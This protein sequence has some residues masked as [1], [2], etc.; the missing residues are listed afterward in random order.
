MKMDL[1]N[2]K[3]F[4]EKSPFVFPGVEK[5]IYIA[6]KISE[7]L[8]INVNTGNI[9]NK[10]EEKAI[11]LKTGRP[12]VITLIRTDYIMKSIDKDEGEESWNMSISEVLVIGS[13]GLESNDKDL[14]SLVPFRNYEDIIKKQE[15]LVNIFQIKPKV[16]QKTQVVDLLRNFKTEKLYFNFIRKY[17]AD[18]R[19]SPEDKNFNMY[20]LTK[21]WL[22]EKRRLIQEN[23]ESLEFSDSLMDNAFMKIIEL[24]F[25]LAYSDNFL[26]TIVL[27]QLLLFLSG[28][29]YY[30]ISCFIYWRSRRS[31]KE[32]VVVGVDLPE[33][34]KQKNLKLQPLLAD[35]IE[36]RKIEMPLVDLYKTNGKHMNSTMHCKTDLAMNQISCVQVY[37]SKTSIKDLRNG[38]RMLANLGET[39]QFPENKIEEKVISTKVMFEKQDNKLKKI[40]QSEIVTVVDCDSEVE[41]LIGKWAEELENYNNDL[42][43]FDKRH[44]TASESIQNFQIEMHCTYNNPN[45]REETGNEDSKN[46][47]ELR[48]TL[49]TSKN[50]KYLEDDYFYPDESLDSHSRPAITIRHRSQVP[51]S[52]FRVRKKSLGHSS[53]HGRLSRV[54]NQP[55]DKQVS[56]KM[57][58]VK[59]DPDE[60]SV[61][62]HNTSVA[63]K[64]IHSNHIEEGRLT[65]NFADL[66]PIGKGGF[67]LVLK[68]THRIEGNF[69]AIKIIKLKIDNF[70]SLV[71][72]QVIKEAKTM[73]KLNHKNVVK[74]ITCWFQTDIEEVL[75][76]EIQENH[77]LIV[78]EGWSQSKY[79]V[80]SKSKA[81]N[82]KF[83]R[84]KPRRNFSFSKV[85]DTINE[86]VSATES[87]M[88]GLSFKSK[89]EAK[90]ERLEAVKEDENDVKF[91]DSEDDADNGK[92]QGADCLGV[93][94]ES[95]K[96]LSISF[97]FD[98]KSFKD[99]E[100]QKRNRKKSCHQMKSHMSIDDSANKSPKLFDVFFIM[101]MEF[102]DGL[103]L[104]TYLEDKK[105][106]GIQRSQIF[107]FF[108][109][110][111]S[112]VIHMHNNKVVHRDIK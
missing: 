112:G 88:S 63:E 54:K 51:E 78:S 33:V 41:G 64:M 58:S 32:P 7:V 4:V 14:N 86:E 31:N 6:N 96:A 109:Q 55:A 25:Y 47:P 26:I 87:K 3:N 74:Y 43:L 105:D 100:K 82:S 101:Q 57:Q 73:W 85:S 107:W 24:Y 65:K 46:F 52:S 106:S 23:T 81:S 80:Y 102:C 84:P 1:K 91:W 40:E 38:T 36:V 13:E 50:K 12:N 108:R 79:S 72:H 92:S 10:V 71:D 83:K 18:H 61:R 77:S 5:Y 97:E 104:S 30:L 27:T 99:K 53:R 75:I 103:P 42:K 90:A 66:Q 37:K 110:I 16:D 19:N 15:S 2:I 49:K 22:K 11:S 93:S 98:D 20:N 35:D 89:S 28:L 45:D 69:Y 34:K 8:L 9:E 60:K 62:R 17:F 95:Q 76:S 59:K 29:V 111:V 21:E 39:I 94:V 48:L 67:G 70:K 68:G 56:N 44:R